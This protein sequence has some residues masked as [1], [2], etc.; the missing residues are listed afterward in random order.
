MMLGSR[1]ALARVLAVAGLAIFL[2]YY[3]DEI[4]K[5][6]GS[7][8]GFLPIASPM[9]RGLAFQL[10]PLILSG[11]AFALSWRRPSILISALLTA[12]GLLM[13]IDGMTTG[14]RFFT[15]LAVPGP[16]IGFVYGIAVLVLGIVKSLR[17]GLALKNVQS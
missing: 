12:T 6:G 2:I 4:A 9:A 11:M 3:L 14:T 5:D 15:N 13:V 8:G 16:V 1:L 17:T 7:V 10:I